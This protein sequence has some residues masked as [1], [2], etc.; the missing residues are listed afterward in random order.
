MTLSKRDSHL[1]DYFAPDVFKQLD[2]AEKAVLYEEFSNNDLRVLASQDIQTIHGRLAS[3]LQNEFKRRLSHIQPEEYEVLK[4]W[5]IEN[6][7]TVDELYC[8]KCG[9]L[10]GLEL[11][12]IDDTMN[13][14]HHEGK[15]VVPIG[16]KLMA[17][18]PRLDGIMGFQCG[19]IIE[20]KYKPDWDKYIVDLDKYETATVKNQADYESAIATYEALPKKKRET[21]ERPT[22]AKDPEV[23]KQPEHPPIE[24]CGN[25]TRW[26]Q[27]EID[28]V[29]EAHVMTSIT[30]EDRIKVKQ[31][32]NATDYTP[33][34][35]ETKS[36][37]TVETFELRK[38]K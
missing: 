25:D 34:V 11:D 27:I 4:P 37:K 9:A 15:F 1:K 2:E 29:P 33:D 10:L 22:R 35:K 28:N 36:G 21:V 24:E 5:Y 26:A 8:T 12:T 18:R 6:C 13:E 16:D 32:I 17:Y 14:F 3:H 7:H 31:E 20:T 23:P 38:V 30:K 19:N